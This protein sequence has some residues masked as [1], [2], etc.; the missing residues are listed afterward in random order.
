MAIAGLIGA[1]AGL[2]LFNLH[3]VRSQATTQP[4][5]QTS[6]EVITDTDAD[7]SSPSHP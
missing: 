3:L 2:Y 1:I 5:T 4:V 7:R 6:P